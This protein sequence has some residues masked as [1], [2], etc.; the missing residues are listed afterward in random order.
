M[1]VEDV[2]GNF[3]L[4]GMMAGVTNV[5][6]LLINVVIIGGAVALILFVLMRLMRFNI[7]VPYWKIVNEGLVFEQDKAFMRFDKVRGIAKFQ[8]KRNKIDL[9]SMINKN[10]YFIPGKKPM[11]GYGDVLHLVLNGNP[12]EIDSWHVVRPEELYKFFANDP[13]LS[14]NR[15]SGAAKLDWLHHNKKIQDELKDLPWFQRPE[16][17]LAIQGIGWGAIIIIMIITGKVIED[18]L[19]QA[20]SA[21]VLTQQTLDAM[22]QALNQMK[23][24]CASQGGTLPPP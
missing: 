1:A 15:I 9:G 7:T 16:W 14:K 5:T 10:I 20:G 13:G 11:W 24:V 3:N 2:I 17:Q 6:V 19:A 23:G 18:I 12:Q 8:L 22:V 4:E 21:N